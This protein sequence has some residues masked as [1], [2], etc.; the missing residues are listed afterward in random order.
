M[1]A[2][3]MEEFEGK[4]WVTLSRFPKY[5][6]GLHGVVVSLMHKTPRVLVPG[7]R[8]K[9]PGFTFVDLYGKHRSVYL[10]RMVAE[11]AHGE[12]KPGQIVRH[13]NGDKVTSNEVNLAWGTYAENL[14]DSRQHGTIA[15]GER[16]GRSTLT[17]VQVLE[18]RRLR[19]EDGLSYR[20]IAKRF[21]VADM[22]AYRAITG[23]NWSHL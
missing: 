3:T 22:T 13:L 7:K 16:S 11:A 8:G 15:V 20:K 23:K 5:L 12:P 9:Y 10:H 18:M 17:T 21:A 2:L 14:E 1:G 19:A 4:T 6:I